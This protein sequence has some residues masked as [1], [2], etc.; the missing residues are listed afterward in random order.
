[1]NLG[2][3]HPEICHILKVKWVT[4]TISCS[5]QLSIPQ[6]IAFGY[7]ELEAYSLEL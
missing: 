5:L 3:F 2:L 1:M 6:T 4:N 7:S